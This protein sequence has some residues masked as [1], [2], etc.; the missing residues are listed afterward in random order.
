MTRQVRF[1]LAHQ[2]G[3]T[4][5][6]LLLV[7]ISG[8]VGHRA[9]ATVGP[10]VWSCLVESGILEAWHWGK[11][12][13]VS[14]WGP[15]RWWWREQAWRPI[16]ARL[17]RAGVLPRVPLEVSNPSMRNDPEYVGHRLG[18]VRRLSFRQTRTA[19]YLR[20]LVRDRGQHAGGSTERDPG[21]QPVPLEGLQF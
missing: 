10:V 15:A 1:R 16:V 20:Q 18:Q 4:L 17:E 3:G 21:G 14:C 8:G 9:G 12:G 7:G 5:G 2:E 6:W 11:T 13:R 19:G